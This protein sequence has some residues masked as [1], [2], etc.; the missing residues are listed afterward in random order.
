M[1]LY[2][3]GGGGVYLFLA[4]FLLFPVTKENT[5][6]NLKKTPLK[7]VEYLMCDNYDLVVTCGINVRTILHGGP[8]IKIFLVM[9]RS[10]LCDEMYISETFIF[11]IHQRRPPEPRSPPSPPPP[12]ENKHCL[13]SLSSFRQLDLRH[14]VQFSQRRRKHCRHTAPPARLTPAVMERS[15]KMFTGS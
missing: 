4:V 11:S 14:Q 6:Y 9:H 5:K 10:P 1:D 15:F 7:P 13:I 8:Y 12:K 3:L 2:K